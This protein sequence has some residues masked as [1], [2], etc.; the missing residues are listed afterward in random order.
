MR[1]GVAWF[2]ESPEFNHWVEKFSEILWLSG[3]PGD[4]KTTLAFCI[5][6]QLRQDRTYNTQRDIA[7]SI[8]GLL[9]GGDTGLCQIARIL[10]TLIVQLTRGS[11]KRREL[12]TGQHR[13]LQ[14]LSP[15]SSSSVSEPQIDDL[16]RLLSAL[17]MA[18][19]S[20][21]LIII[22]DAVDEIRGEAARQ[23]FLK[24]LLQLHK[25]VLAEGRGIDFKILV[26][27]RSY[28][29]ITKELK[30]LPSI[31]RDTERQGRLLQ[32]CS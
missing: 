16:W 18:L 31:E 6:D 4:G 2:F 23:K 3:K 15:P 10:S 5:W 27:S 11:S 13:L 28:D 32:E 26:T 25:Q 20:H 9:Q 22:I 17:I 29:D 14:S 30:A 19:P 12:V 7:F 8:C 24:N 1:D 21:Q